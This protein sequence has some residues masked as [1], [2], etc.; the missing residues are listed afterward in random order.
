VNSHP[1]GSGRRN[2]LKL[3]VA[4]AGGA[5]ASTGCGSS[6]SAKGELQP[7]G[8]HFP[9]SIASGDPRPESVVL[10]TR[11][12]DGARAGEDLELELEL[13]RDETFEDLVEL[14]G[15]PRMR[16]VA[17][18][19]SDGC[20]KIL[21]TSL[22]P[23]TTYFYRFWYGDV[24]S[25]VGRTRTAPSDDADVRL[26]F[27]VV[28]CQDYDRRYY[29]VLRRLSEQDLDFV[30]H[31]GDYVYEGGSAERSEPR[32]VVFGRPN[33]AL[34]LGAN[35]GRPFV[36][37][38]V[39]NYRDLYRTIRSDRDLQALHERAPFIVIPDDHEFSD[40]SHGATATYSE[41]RRDETDFERKRASDRAWFE[42]MPV[43]FTSGTA[44]AL[45]GSADFPN[46]FRIYRSF[47]FGRHLE[48]VMTDLRRYRP[49][50]LIP[51]DAFPGSV[52]LLAED[53]PEDGEAAA[54][55]VPYVDVDEFEGG[56]YG[57][58]L[59]SAADELGFRS[60]SVT[61]P[62]SVPWINA[63]L[64]E[65]GGAPGVIE[66]TDSMQRGLAYHQ[67][68][69]TEEFSRVGS[70]YFVAQ[71]PFEALAAAR[72]RETGG[73]SENL[74]GTAQREWFTSTL[75]AS[76]RTFKVWG[77]EVA[78]MPKHLDLTGLSSAPPELRQ[79]IGLTA[80][81]WDGFP[82]ERRALL[83]EL[84]GVENVVVLAGDL[85]CFFA[86]T[87]YDP[88]DASRQFT[89][90]VIGS[91]TSQTWKDGLSGIVAAAP[92]LPPMVLALAPYV[93]NL[94]MTKVPPA[95]PHMAYQELGKNGC[96]VV[97]VSEEAFEIELWM[98]DPAL[99][100]TPPEELEGDLSTLFESVRFRVPNGG[101]LERE[102]AAGG[103]ER[104][105]LDRMEWVRAD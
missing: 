104:W 16:V 14:S 102:A 74:M 1:E 12:V 77:S 11:V 22:E 43:D 40:D 84:E 64:A 37:R 70:R 58:A 27:G 63:T 2:F 60:A 55:A 62:L 26:R 79:R 71:G 69:K 6:S 99:V 36:A 34:G 31:L 51:E 25:R 32:D 48:L 19:G 18:A 8:E 92:S 29:H 78:F 76:T 3:V 45:D 17:E 35:G 95:N 86:G 73:Q 39:D 38:S 13:A 88:S 105:D 82:N 5:W 59:R 56:V 90:F 93:G 67:L 54:L 42:Y 103:F 49:D 46:D 101:G 47:V 52:F 91:V 33:E 15:A 96:G 28:S 50:H 44:T 85:H 81:D 98:L 68:L 87:P 7:P 83:R 97:T 61:G 94:L 23:G 65:V 9:Q 72:L 20:V 75:R 24:P 21:V 30:V 100:A 41:G 66:E 53:L 57:E 89:E 80:E 10:W 4:V